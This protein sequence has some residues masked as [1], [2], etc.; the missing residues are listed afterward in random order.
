VPTLEIQNWSLFSTG[1]MELSIAL[2][3]VS[4]RCPLG[5]MSSFDEKLLDYDSVNE[6]LRHVPCSRNLLLSLK[7]IDIPRPEHYDSGVPGQK[8]VRCLIVSGTKRRFV[9]HGFTLVELLVVIA[10]VSIL[11]SLL[12]PALSRAK[13]RGR[14]AVCLSNLSQVGKACTMYALDND[15]N[16]FPA[17]DNSIQIALDP[18]QEKAAIVAGLMGKIW[19]CPNR[20]LFPIYE[21]TENQWLIGY[22]YFGGITNWNTPRGLLPSASPIKLARAK[23]LWALAADAT[24]KIDNVWKGGSNIAFADMPPHANSK[25]QAEGG[26]QVHVD[27]SARWV[28]FDTMYFVQRLPNFRGSSCQSFFFQEDLGEYGRR[29]PIRAA[30]AR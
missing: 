18:L 16:Y 1:K 2:R 5:K 25:N 7:A 12:L 23:P 20:P 10:I 21:P 4:R 3:L 27:G 11:A 26:N 15:D 14:R 6:K 17:R 13:E 29:E 8:T 28:A 22:Q 30:N 19:S 9:C 24:M